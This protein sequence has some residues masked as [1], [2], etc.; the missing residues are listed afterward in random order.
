MRPVTDLQRTVAPKC[1]GIH[2][3]NN[4]LGWQKF[5]EIRGQ[6]IGI[7]ANEGQCLPKRICQPEFGKRLANQ[8]GGMAVSWNWSS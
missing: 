7:D 2:L 3:Q 5:D 4:G 6:E 1:L 8:S